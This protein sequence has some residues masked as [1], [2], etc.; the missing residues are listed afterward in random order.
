[1]AIQT[2]ASTTIGLVASSPATHDSSGFAALTFVDIGEVVS[3]GEHGGTAALITHSPLASRTVLKQKGSINYGSIPIGFGLDISDAGQ[4][5]LEAGATGTNV[6]V[7]HSIK[8][9]YQD[10]SVEYFEA[11]IMSYTRNPSTIDAIVS[12]TATLELVTS[13]V[14]A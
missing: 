7:D 11:K 10:A 2:N 4:V 8:I 5:L 12:G 3:I 14:D 1:M 6:D 13:I 9:T